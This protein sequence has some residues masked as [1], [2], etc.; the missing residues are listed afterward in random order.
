MGSSFSNQIEQNQNEQND[1]QPMDYN[2]ISRDLTNTQ[3]S[4]FLNSPFYNTVK[5]STLES[6]GSDYRSLPTDS[7]NSVNIDTSRSNE[8]IDQPPEYYTSTSGGSNGFI[9]Y[10]TKQ[11]QYINSPFTGQGTFSTISV[12][13]LALGR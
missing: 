6:S 8:I 2:N 7:I 13:V 10:E 3:Y 1:S 12:N 9:Y 4:N 5:I 11:N